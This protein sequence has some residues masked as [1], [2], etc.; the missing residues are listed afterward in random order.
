MHVLGPFVTQGTLNGGGEVQESIIAYY[1]YVL[2][3]RGLHHKSVPKG[4]GG[5]LEV[6]NAKK[7]IT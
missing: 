7:S 3:D 6:K 1:F 2:N 4:E 5:V